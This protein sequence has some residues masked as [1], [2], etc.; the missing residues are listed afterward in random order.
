[1][2]W[3]QFYV[4]IY[5]RTPIVTLVKT[6]FLAKKLRE[7]QE[8]V[9]LDWEC[10]GFLGYSGTAKARLHQRLVTKHTKPKMFDFEMFDH[11]ANIKRIVRTSKSILNKTKIEQPDFSVEE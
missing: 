3:K 7:G 10:S 4:T 8:S 1:M 6:E 9:F 5:I 2:Y 11:L